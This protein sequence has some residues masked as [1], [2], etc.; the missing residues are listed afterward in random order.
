MILKLFIKYLL[1]IYTVI[2]R[3]RLFWTKLLSFWTKVCP[4]FVQLCPAF[5]PSL[6]AKRLSLIRHSEQVATR[7]VTLSKLPGRLYSWKNCDICQNWTN[8]N[9]SKPLFKG[10]PI[11]IHFYN[12]T[13]VFQ[14]FSKA[15]LIL[16][17]S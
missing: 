14:V 7:H 11:F 12:R 10:A 17:K 4:M 8:T 6:S 2:R 16:F 13:F 1:F 15:L 9:K 5:L 3:F